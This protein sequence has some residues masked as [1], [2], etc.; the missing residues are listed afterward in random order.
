MQG[1]P[2]GS[3]DLRTF[4]QFSKSLPSFVQH[5]FPVQGIDSRHTRA[6]AK[7]PCGGSWDFAG[8]RAIYSMGLSGMLCGVVIRDQ[9]LFSDCF[10]IYGLN[11]PGYFRL[12]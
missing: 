5:S 2:V 7:P 9:T 6:A 11:L 4:T 1:R 8:I 3:L 10:L 12:F